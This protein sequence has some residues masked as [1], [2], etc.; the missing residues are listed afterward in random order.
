MN[1]TARTW[2]VAGLVGFVLT[3]DGPLRA[4]DAGRTALRP[5]SVTVRVFDPGKGVSSGQDFVL[6]VD[7]PDAEHAAASTMANARSVG[8]R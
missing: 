4:E 8:V 7:N 1:F 3:L 6:P 2:A 5:F